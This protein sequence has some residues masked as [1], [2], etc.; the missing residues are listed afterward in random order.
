MSK[1]DL[2]YYRFSYLIHAYG[3]LHKVFFSKRSCDFYLSV[4][5]TGVIIKFHK[6]AS[7]TG[8]QILFVVGLNIALLGL[9]LATYAIIFSIQDIAFLGALVSSKNYQY[10]LFQTTWTSLW[11]FTSIGLFG[12]LVIIK[13]TLIVLAFAVFA[14]TYSL[15]G[16]VVIVAINLR[17]YAVMAARRTPELMKA[18]EDNDKRLK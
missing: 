2:K 6:F 13:F 18:W 17:K 5:V 16:T 10:L 7:L 11:I 1:E 4:I 3:G 12:F 8:S 14:T 9:I 15:L